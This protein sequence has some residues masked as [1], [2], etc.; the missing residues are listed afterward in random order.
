MLELVIRN[1]VLKTVLKWNSVCLV[2]L[3][4][5]LHQRASQTKSFRSARASRNITSAL[6]SRWTSQPL[7]SRPLRSTRSSPLLVPF[8]SFT[9]C[10]L[11]KI[12][13]QFIFDCVY[14]MV[15]S[16][17]TFTVEI[18]DSVE[19]YAEMLRDIFDFA[20]LK[21]LLSGPNHINVR[22]DAMHGGMNVI[23]PKTS[24]TCMSPLKL[25]SYIKQLKTAFFCCSSH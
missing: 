20:A 10:Q 18:V 4:Q 1:E 21:E 6:S 11:L 25:H 3:S 22:L 16:L 17:V 8:L 9:I 2:F 19:S 15:Y 23:P 12:I 5:V 13:F 24:K 7:G 14:S